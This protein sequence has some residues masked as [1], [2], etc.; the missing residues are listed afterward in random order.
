MSLWRYRALPHP[1][2]DVREERHGVPGALK[3]FM[4]HH[5]LTP[6]SDLTETMLWTT[7][8]DFKGR[9]DLAMLHQPTG[10]YMAAEIAHIY[11]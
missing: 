7:A 11:F 9:M 2:H 6:V 10:A 8:G 5:D 3:D 4:R 1:G